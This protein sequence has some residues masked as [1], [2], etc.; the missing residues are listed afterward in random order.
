MFLCIF[1]KFADIVT[2]DDAGL[3]TDDIRENSKFDRIRKR[4]VPG[5]YQEHPCFRDRRIRKKNEGEWCE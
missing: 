4:V 3:H 2:S 5:R 1:E